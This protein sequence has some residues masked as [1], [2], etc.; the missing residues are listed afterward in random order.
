MYILYCCIDS[1]YISRL[2]FYVPFIELPPIQYKHY[3]S[4]I[5]RPIFQATSP[6]PLCLR[7]PSPSPLS[8]FKKAIHRLLISLTANKRKKDRKKS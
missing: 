1:V 7:I 6:L 8:V 4:P 2:P 3:S 5:P